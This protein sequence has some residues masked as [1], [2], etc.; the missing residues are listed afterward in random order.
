MWKAESRNLKN[1]A[2]SSKA[3]QKFGK[4]KAEIDFCFLFSAFYF[5]V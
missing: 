3:K 5:P 2:E 4:L 1:K